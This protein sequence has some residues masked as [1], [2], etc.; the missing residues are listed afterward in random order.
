VVVRLVVI[1]GGRLLNFV[2]NTGYAEIIMQQLVAEV[3]GSIYY[4]SEGFRLEALNCF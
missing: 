3:P 2:R 4:A 1:F